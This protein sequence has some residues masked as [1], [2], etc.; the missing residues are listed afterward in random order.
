M[1]D[2]TD[3]SVEDDDDTTLLFRHL[4]NVA[5]SLQSI[6]IVQPGNSSCLSLDLYHAIAGTD[7]SEPVP[8]KV[9]NASL[10]QLTAIDS[11]KSLRKFVS[12]RSGSDL[13]STVLQTIFLTTESSL[14]SQEVT[15]IRLLCLVLACIAV[16]KAPMDS[17]VTPPTTLRP[18][19]WQSICFETIRMYQT[20]LGLAQHSMRENP[21]EQYILSEWLSLW[22]RV[23]V[24][25][26]RL[27]QNKLP[28]SEPS[29]MTAY[30]VGVASTC[31]SL[32][33]MVVEQSSSEYHH[34]LDELYNL[35]GPLIGKDSLELLARIKQHSK[36]VASNDHRD[37]SF[38]YWI[39]QDGSEDVAGIHTD[40]DE[41][42][43]AVMASRHVN[44]ERQSTACTNCVDVPQIESQ[45]FF[46]TWI[47]SVSFLLSVTMDDFSNEDETE[48]PTGYASDTVQWADKVTSRYHNLGLDLLE[49]MLA[50]L[51]EG[52]LSVT[53]DSLQ[54]NEL[55]SSSLGIM[56]LLAN[57]IARAAMGH[58]ADAMDDMTKTCQKTFSVMQRVVNVHDSRA[59][60]RIVRQLVTN[61]PYME[62]RSKLLDLLRRP[63]C[64]KNFDRAGMEL[65]YQFLD[66]DILQPL[67]THFPVF[68][69]ASVVDRPQQLLLSMELY[70]SALN[71]L[72]LIRFVTRSEPAILNLHSRITRVRKTLGASLDR[73]QKDTRHV[74][75][76]MDE[77][78]RL[79][80]L[81]MS[82]EKVLT[83]LDLPPNE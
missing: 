23:V 38:S 70:D 83:Q 66:E 2:E 71:L 26:T 12:C 32:A 47:E 82:L 67:E 58:D 50:I 61:C 36:R 55:A 5:Q 9:M 37:E 48:Q 13:H 54:P 34:E 44:H 75:P 28:L 39:E 33:R 52:S 49:N 51:P 76:E 60:V 20:Q 6:N 62:L 79:G 30:N 3:Q 25:C 22:I 73:W 77:W 56:Q 63:V 27:L 59:Q 45:A 80:L 17:T 14:A 31:F 19:R 35:M 43:L 68:G 74:P 42:G 81:D 64:G 4:R 69:D 24:P 41:F 40:V 18:R 57:R 1:P 78:F 11:L 10:P 72:Y 46:H 7:A 29:K 8:A 21:A 53:D 15:A 16:D 65:L